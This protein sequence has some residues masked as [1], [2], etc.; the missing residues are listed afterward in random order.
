MAEVQSRMN[1][2]TSERDL[3]LKQQQDAKGELV[4]LSFG[5][6]ANVEEEV[7]SC[8]LQEDGTGCIGTKLPHT[9]ASDMSACF[10]H[11]FPLL[12]RS[13]CRCSGGADGGQAGCC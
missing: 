4:Q 13:P 11:T 6:A 12:C 7:A 1:V 5:A 10:M 2:A 9:P 3:L 8:A